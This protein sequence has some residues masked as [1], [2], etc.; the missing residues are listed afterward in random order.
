MTHPHLHLQAIAYDST[1]PTCKQLFVTHHHLYVVTYDSTLPSS[2]TCSYF[3][4]S[5]TYMQ[6]VM[7]WHHL[8]TYMQFFDLIFSITWITMLATQPHSYA[9]IYDF[10]S[11]S[12][13]WSCL[14]LNSHAFSHLHAVTRC[15]TSTEISNEAS[16]LQCTVA[17]PKSSA[18]T[19]SPVAAYESERTI[20]GRITYICVKQNSHGQCLLFFLS[21]EGKHLGKF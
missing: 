19:T 18:E 20:S 7:T 5:L 12:L 11:F 16:Y 8:Y 4:L 9:V 15:F 17:P 1:S 10:T 13:A 21:K 6:L 3:W 2:H 14:W